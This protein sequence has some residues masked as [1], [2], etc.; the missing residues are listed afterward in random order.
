MLVSPRK[1]AAIGPMQQMEATRAA[2]TEAAIPAVVSDLSFRSF[3]VSYPHG[4]IPTRSIGRC[5]I[6]PVKV[7]LRMLPSQERDIQDAGDNEQSDRDE[8]CSPRLPDVGED[9]QPDRAHA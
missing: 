3:I 1:A 6:F 9:D 7:S 2:I 5:K 8:R 4:G